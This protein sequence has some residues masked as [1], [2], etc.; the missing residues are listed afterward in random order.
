M[1]VSRSKRRSAS[2]WAPRHFEVVP[3]DAGEAGMARVAQR[4]DPLQRGR[5]AVQLGQRRDGMG[6]VE[7]EHLGV[8]QPA[9]GVELVAHA[10]GVGPQRLAG[11]EDLVAVRRQVRPDHRLGRPVLRRDVE[12]VHPA[13]QGLAQPRSRLLFGGRPAGG[14]AQNGHAALVPGPAQASTFHVAAPLGLELE[15]VE[16][17]PDRVGQDGH[18]SRLDVHRAHEE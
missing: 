8:E 6:L 13:G 2:R 9:G 1:T 5:A 10:V 17:R 7:V 3:G 15:D 18:A 14:A 12:V 16:H 11:D 4:H